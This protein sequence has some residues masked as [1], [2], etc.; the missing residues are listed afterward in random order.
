[1]NDF[2]NAIMQDV[3]GSGQGA[4]RHLEPLASR[5]GT[6][7]GGDAEGPPGGQEEGKREGKACKEVGAAGWVQPTLRWAELSDLVQTLPDNVEV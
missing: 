7:G 2:F 3:L 6:R 5:M 4:G 1:M